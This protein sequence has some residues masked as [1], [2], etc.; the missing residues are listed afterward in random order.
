MNLYQFITAIK[1]KL[2]TSPIILSLE[3]VDERILLNRDYFLSGQIK[4]IIL[5]F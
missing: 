3:I 5:Q 1:E 4:W 2:N